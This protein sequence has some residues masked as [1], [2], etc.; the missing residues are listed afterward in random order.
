MDQPVQHLEKQF[1][2]LINV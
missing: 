1:P 2:L